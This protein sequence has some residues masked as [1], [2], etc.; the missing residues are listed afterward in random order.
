[1][2]LVL[3]NGKAFVEPN[4][5]RN[6]EPNAEANVKGKIKPT[7]MD[8][9]CLWI[10]ENWSVPSLGFATVSDSHG[11]GDVLDGGIAYAMAFLNPSD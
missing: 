11:F 4:A 5:E 3:A 7:R 2:R 8:R 10:Q 9:L 6:A 1:M